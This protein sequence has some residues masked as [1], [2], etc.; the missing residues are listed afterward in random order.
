[1]LIF[2]VILQQV[3][4][5][6]LRIGGIAIWLMREAKEEIEYQGEISN[7][8]PLFSIFFLFYN[9]YEM[10]LFFSDYVIPKG[11]FV[12]PFL[13]AVHLDENIYEKATTFNPWRWMEPQNPVSIY[14][15]TLTTILSTYFENA[16]THVHAHTHFESLS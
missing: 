14:F 5:E 9:L 15:Y 13:S 2:K 3:I 1:M 6:T 4:D 16:L 7:K 11:C 8:H 12:V 10:I